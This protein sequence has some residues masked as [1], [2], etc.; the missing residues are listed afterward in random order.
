MVWEGW[1]REAPPYPDFRAGKQWLGPAKTPAGGNGEGAPS[2][3]R[4]QSGARTAPAQD[5]RRRARARTQDMRAK[6]VPPPGRNPAAERNAM[7]ERYA[8]MERQSIG[9]GMENMTSHDET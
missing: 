6:R 7:E 1:S 5:A 2:V 8:G 4:A 9:E 3:S